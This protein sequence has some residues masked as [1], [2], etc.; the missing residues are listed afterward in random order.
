MSRAVIVGSDF[1]P[2]PSVEKTR[3]VRVSSAAT[4]P[5]E[6]D[7]LGIAV[8]TSGEPPRA[9]GL[10]RAALSAAGFDGKLGQTLTIP[11]A[12]G[13]SMICLGLAMWPIS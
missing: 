7:A 10:R 13:V 2:V 8:G 11:A 9:L 12:D 6:A 4:V 3:A 5:A 1:N